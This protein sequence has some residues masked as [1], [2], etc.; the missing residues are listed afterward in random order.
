MFNGTI[1]YKWQFSIAMLVY[2]R[3]GKYGKIWNIWELDGR[4]HREDDGN[5]MIKQGESPSFQ[6]FYRNPNGLLPATMMT[7]PSVGWF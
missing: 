2:Q 6:I 1:Q 7:T 5:L 3:V 4:F